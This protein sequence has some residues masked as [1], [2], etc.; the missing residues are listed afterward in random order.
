MNRKW[1]GLIAICAAVAPLLSCATGQ[2]LV[3][4]QV[5]PA[6]VI[7]GSADPALNA[8]LTAVGTY[9]HPPATKDITT[10]VTWTSD[11]TGVAQ[12]TSTGEVSPNTDCG[13]ANITASLKTNTPSGNV[14]TGTMTAT[15][16]GPSG[17]GCPSTPT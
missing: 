5:T 12:V 11:I 2:Q 4:I 10:Q 13:I 7:F 6:A 1:L 16:N 17:S 15:V 3:A 8:Q 9:T 14:V